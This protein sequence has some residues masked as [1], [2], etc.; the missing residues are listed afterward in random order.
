MFNCKSYDTDDIQKIKTRP[1]LTF[2]F[3]LI[4]VPPLELVTT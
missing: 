2:Y 3:I 1:K 4:H